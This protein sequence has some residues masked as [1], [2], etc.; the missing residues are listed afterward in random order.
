MNFFSLCARRGMWLILCRSS[1]WN[2]SHSE[3]TKSVVLTESGDT[4]F[5]CSSLSCVSDNPSSPFFLVSET[6]LD[7]DALLPAE[8][9]ADA[10]LA[11]RHFIIAYSLHF[12]RFCVSA[13]T[14][15]THRTEQYLNM[16]CPDNLWLS[17]TWHEVN[18]VITLAPIFVCNCCKIRI[19]QSIK[20]LSSSFSASRWHILPWN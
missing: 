1:L 11:A 2:H 17:V 13:L 12:N 18:L 7:S 6:M 19:S 3:F 15:I 10:I 4:V 8:C 5:L 20:R 9:G 16:E 14:A